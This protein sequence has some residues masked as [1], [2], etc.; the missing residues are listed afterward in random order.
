MSQYIYSYHPYLEAFSS[1]C[2]LRMGHA[3]VTRDPLNMDNF[4]NEKQNIHIYKCPKTEQLV[5]EK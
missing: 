5:A 4:K 1:I 3:V 2:N